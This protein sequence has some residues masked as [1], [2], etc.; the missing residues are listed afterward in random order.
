[1]KIISLCG[2]AKLFAERL[3]ANNFIMA[4]QFDRVSRRA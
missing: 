2:D 4:V 1:M 3:Y